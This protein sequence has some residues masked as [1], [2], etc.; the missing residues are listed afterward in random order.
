M[1]QALGSSFDHFQ[2][3][4]YLLEHQSS[5]LSRLNAATVDRFEQLFIRLNALL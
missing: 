1:E 3:A 5:I 2:P 4:R